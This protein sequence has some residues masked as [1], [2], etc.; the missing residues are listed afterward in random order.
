MPAWKLISLLVATILAILLSLSY[1]VSAQGTHTLATNVVPSQGGTVKAD[2][3]T[4]CQYTPGTWAHLLAIPSSGYVFGTWYV[5]DTWSGD[6]SGSNPSAVIRMDSPKTCTATFTPCSDWPLRRGGYSFDTFQDAYSAPI[7]DETIKILATTLQESIRLDDTISV[8]L[9]GGYRC[10]FT[11]NP[12]Y[13]LLQGQLIGSG[14]TLTLENLMVLSGTP[15]LI[16]SF[17]ANPMTV[18][19]GKSATLTWNVADAV[20]VT[21]NQ[22]IGAVDAISGSRVISPSA[23]TVYTLTATNPYGTVTKHVTVAIG[24][25]VLPVITGFSA[26]PDVLSWGETTTTLTWEVSGALSVYIDQGIGSVNPVS[27]TVQRS[28]TTTT[29]YTITASNADGTVEKTITVG[30]IPPDPATVAP[31]VDP[32]VATT[33]YTANE[34]LYSWSSPVQTGVAADT[35]EVTRAAL[36]RGKVMDQ[37]NNPLQGVT[38]TI[39]YHPEYGQT[40]TR[41]DG[42]FDIAVNGGGDLTVTYAKTAY[43]PAQRQ[44]NVPWQGYRDI[45]DTI[46]A[47]Q[48]ARLN[49]VDLTNTTQ[50]FQVAQG[51][52]VTDQDGTRQATLLIPQGTQAWVYNQDGTTRSVT[53]LNLRLTEY[54]VGPN[55]PAAMPALLPPTSAYTYAVELKA[56]EATLKLNGKDVLFDRPVPVYV[57]N[58]LGFPV[59]GAVPAGY[60]DSDRGAWVPRDNGRVIKILAISGGSAE[61]DTDGDGLADEAAKLAALGITD[62][63]CIQLASL[64]AEGQSLWRVQV[65]HLSTWDLNWPANIEPGAQWPRQKLPQHAGSTVSNP[66]CQ[67]G[68]GEVEC[69]NQVLREQMPLAGTGMKLAYSSQRMPGATASRSLTIPLSGDSIHPKLRRIDLVVEVAARRFMQSFPPAVNQS[70]EFVW[71]GLDAIGRPLYGGQRARILLGY[72]YDTYY[73]LPA[74]SARSFG[75]AGSGAMAVQIPTRQQ[76]A[77][78]QEETASLWAWNA[79]GAGLGGWSLD[80]HHFYDPTS[81]VLHL[82]DG[83]RRNDIATIVDRIAGGGAIPPDN[84]GDGLPAKDINLDLFG[85][86]VGPDGSLY[87]AEANRS[88]VRRVGPDGIITTIAGNGQEGFSGDGGPATQAMMVSPQAVAVAP[89]GSVYIADTYNYRLRRVDPNGIIST[90]AGNGQPSY[91]GDGGPATGASIYGPQDLAVGPDGSV[92]ISTAW[93]PRVRKVSPDGIITTVAGNGQYTTNVD[94]VAA[95]KTSVTAQGIAIGPDG[96]LYI[97]DAWHNRIRRVTTDGIINTIVGG[98]WPYCA[99]SGDGGPATQARICVPNYLMVTPDGVLYFSDSN[100]RIRRVGTDGIITS[101]AGNGEGYTELGDGGPALQSGLEARHIATDGKGNVIFADGTRQTIRVLKPSFGGVT[102]SETLVPSED[103]QQLYRFDAS[104][105]HLSTVHALTGATLHRFAYDPAGRLVSVT[106]GNSNVTRV[107]RDAGGTPTAIVGPYGQR[108]V[109]TLDQEGYL[110]AVTDPAGGAATYTYGPG[111]LMTRVTGPRGYRFDVTHDGN[112]RVTGTADQAGGSTSFTRTE[113]TSSQ[114]VVS[115]TALGL[116]TTYFTTTLA[117]GGEQRLATYPDGTA[118]STVDSPDGRT[119]RTDRAGTTTNLTRGPDPRFGMLAPVETQRTVKTPGGLTATMATVREVQLSTP[120]NPLSLVSLT[121][122]W[123]VN[124]VDYVS[125]YLAASRSFTLTTPAGR[126]YQT[127]ID[128]QGRPLQTTDPGHGTFSFTYDSHGRPAALVRGSGGDAR[129]STSAYDTATG[130]LAALVDPLG[131]SISFGHDAAGRATAVTRPDGMSTAFSYDAAG[132]VVGVTPPDRGAHTFTYTPVDLTAT[133]T[134]PAVDGSDPATRYTYNADR[135]LTRVDRPDGS[136][137]AFGYGADG[138]LQT[139]TT[140]HDV[141]IYSYSPTTGAL[142]GLATQE[143][144]SVAIDYD[145]TLVN[146]MTWSGAVAGSVAMG[147]DQNFRVTSRSV[148]GQAAAFTHDADGLLLQAGDLTIQR[149]AASGLVTATALGTVTDSWSYDSF[150]A[151][152]AY[153]AS[154]GGSTLYSAQYT[155]DKL[156][157]VVQKQETIAGVTTT[158]SYTYD[159]ANRLTGV[160]RNGT[161]SASCSYDGNG[162][163]VTYTGSGGAV[164]GT[165]D[166]QDRLVSYGAVTYTYSPGGDMTG[167][168]SGGGTTT[169]AYDALGNLRSVQRPSQP[170]IDYV[171]DG[172]NRRVGKKVEGTPVKGFLYQEDRRVVAELDGSNSV[173]SRFLYGTR[174]NVPDCM[175]RWDGAGWVAYR[176]VADHLGSVRLAVKASDGSIAQRIDYDEFGKPTFT[177]GPADF[178]PFG[179]AG[180]LYD[181]DTGLVRFGARDYDAEVGRWTAKDPLGFAGGDT[182]L[183]AYAFGDPVN[184]LDPS[185]LGPRQN[186]DWAQFWTGAKQIGGGLLT[187]GV[188][189]AVGFFLAAPS[190]GLVVPIS[191]MSILSGSANIGIG[192]DNMVRA[193]IA[194]A[195]PTTP[196]IQKVLVD[197]VVKDMF[198]GV[199]DFVEQATDWSSWQPAHQD[200]PYFRN[201]CQFGGLK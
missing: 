124:D 102:T 160:S 117:A 36:I 138:K 2:C 122:T 186:V 38:I 21:I 57:T 161:P 12:S 144:E 155:R 89:D 55:G 142:S 165:F 196:T 101:V 105:R 137:I 82:G 75:L 90:F 115:R 88:R 94:G 68:S 201:Q 175:L 111:G 10:G 47:S 127:V 62:Q 26:T 170:R 129:S 19:A 100:Y 45:A 169:Y 123:T 110:S 177:V 41:P 156:G 53:N 24:Q 18:Q 7:A 49:T 66:N 154:A 93:D 195:S 153:A 136:V 141:V 23:T 32:T 171:I 166:A 15:P 198:P 22:G 92:Y 42:M 132:N 91:G 189:G 109:L 73:T 65:G 95:T 173:V 118:G 14:G 56:E 11:E 4:P 128:S 121:D 13:T 67:S 184:R 179:F 69:Q 17:S 167:R 29:A 64:Y 148:N 140:D 191:V 61:L 139:V 43:L 183:Y 106:D 34:F 63:E 134:P 83:R 125:S 78:W 107:E 44:M 188:S 152:S 33:V 164:T 39:L 25:P 174:G 76:A 163:R 176:I 130:Y 58:F 71:D 6:C 119:I 52:V 20:T 28:L 135:Q 98:A 8:T 3:G 120:A 193:V 199:H 197:T 87:I 60:Y 126:Q 79:A 16:N 30:V 143:G 50:P 46:L 96:S 86:A 40:I 178:Q 99:F 74:D 85:I 70:Y 182:N 187:I 9:K 77:L 185:G 5:F 146:G 145:G 1:Q 157:R 108:T 190:G 48:D 72:V 172:A 35:I 59:G 104:G 151:L 51:S 180:G 37:D 131:R 114:A 113:T 168:T 159:A 116:T 54:T 84:V 133:Y 150:G 97:A 112:G 103:G 194:P 27:G 147:Y 200:D 149:A 158:Y 162:N 181:P 31:P 81:G 80:L 192:F